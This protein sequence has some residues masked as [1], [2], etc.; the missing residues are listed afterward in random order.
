MGKAK[1]LPPSKDHEKREMLDMFVPKQAGLLEMFQV[2]GSVLPRCLIHATAGALLGGLLKGF[3]ADLV[4]YQE[5]WIHPYSL[6]V[7]AT[8]LGFSLVMRIQIAYGRLWEGASACH[9][10][11]SKWSDAVMQV[12]AFDEASKDAFEEDAL[13]FRM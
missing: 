1:V 2:Y 5:T 12:V 4:E 7:F 9:L 6:H 8:V 3:N 13:E 11:A 10:A